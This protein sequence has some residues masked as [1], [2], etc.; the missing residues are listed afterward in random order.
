MLA[1]P[2]SIWS[3]LLLVGLVVGAMFV[4]LGYGMILLPMVLILVAVGLGA[5][6]AM[7]GS[8]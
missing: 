7:F 2:L 3:V 6:G 8:R 4:V 5:A 1:R